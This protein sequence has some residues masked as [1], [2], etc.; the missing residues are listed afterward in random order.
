M[1]SLLWNIADISHFDL[2]VSQN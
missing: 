1:S 2:S